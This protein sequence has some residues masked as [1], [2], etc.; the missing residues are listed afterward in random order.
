MMIANNSASVRVLGPDRR[1]FPP[2]CL[3]GPSVVKCLGIA[4]MISPFKYIGFQTPIFSASC[5]LQHFEANPLPLYSYLK[6]KTTFFK[7]L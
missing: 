3:Q 2:G 1:S 6:L 4:I 7:I 5:S